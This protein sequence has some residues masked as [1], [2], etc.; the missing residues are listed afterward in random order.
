[1]P[2]LSFDCEIILTKL[3]YFIQNEENFLWFNK[4]EQY[5]RN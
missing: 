1:M 5:K 3:I 4:E 2:K